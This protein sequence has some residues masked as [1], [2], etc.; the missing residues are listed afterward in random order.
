MLSQKLGE[1]H[2]NTSLS[3][4]ISYASQTFCLP[5]WVLKLW[6]CLHTIISHCWSWAK[7]KT[8]LLQLSNTA[9]GCKD[10]AQDM[11]NQLS[12][13]PVDS[14]I[15]AL[16]PFRTS[17]LPDLLCDTWLSDDHINA[18]SEFITLHPS[19]LP[20]IRVLNSFFIEHLRRNFERS[21][22]WSPRCSTKL[23][24]Q[25]AS[26][27]VTDLLIPV[28]CPSH[29]TFLYVNIAARC[30]SYAD[31]LQVETYHAPWSTIDLINRWLSGV[32]SSNI[33]L[34][35]S[36][37]PFALGKQCDSH[38]CGVAVLSSIAHYALGGVF[39]PWTQQSTKEHRLQWALW[40]S[41][42]TVGFRSVCGASIYLIIYRTDMTICR[43][44]VGRLLPLMTFL[45]LNQV[46]R[47]L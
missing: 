41:N 14:T 16:T 19:C 6:P 46:R 26:R 40:L 23:D 10:L 33:L 22:T 17:D 1:S 35:P 39:Q 31:T 25:V 8:M 7:A 3:I 45:V 37:R 28:H 24:N 27:T 42:P 5:P 29:W 47:S 44:Y 18:G 2:P 9:G 4:A 21:S 36:P 13:I 38:S 15:P 12:M 43:V 20:S 32:L 34:L 30:Y 11:L